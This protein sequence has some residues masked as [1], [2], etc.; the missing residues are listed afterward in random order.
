V[1]VSGYKLWFVPSRRLTP[2]EETAFGSQGTNWQPPEDRFRAVLLRPGDTLVMRPGYM[3]PHFVLTGEDSLTIGGMEWVADSLPSIMQQL[4]FIIP[5][6]MATN[7]HV[8]RQI[9]EILDMLEDLVTRQ[10]C[11][12]LEILKT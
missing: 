5:R 6:Y 3:I 12:F 2:L 11:V 8:P 10:A 9:T 1:V 7:E 4:K